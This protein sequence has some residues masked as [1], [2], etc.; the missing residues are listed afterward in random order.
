MKENQMTPETTVLTAEFP[1]A[2]RGYSIV[3]VDDFVSQLGS[4]LDLL[5]TRLDEQILRGDRLS[6]ELS[7]ANQAVA[8]FR[9]KESALA[10]AL[11]ATEQRREAV[12]KELDSEAK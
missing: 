2:V 4:R 6:E 5:Q 1:R 7:R 10:G 9:N 12:R 8:E 11:V 3:A